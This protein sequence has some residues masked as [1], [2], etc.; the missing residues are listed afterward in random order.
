MAN[1]SLKRK[2]IDTLKEWSVLLTNDLSYSSTETLTTITWLGSPVYRK[3]ID[4]GALPNATS[5]I[6][7]HG[8]TG[9]NYS[10]KIEGIAISGNTTI[11]L[12][13]SNDTGAGGLNS[14]IEIF[15]NNTNIYIYT[16]Q[17]LTSWNGY[18]TLFYIK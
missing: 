3:T 16:G 13:Y 15:S 9:L 1:Y 18:V 8:I 12:P 7:A 4:V 11:P 5:K 14:N 17:D 6:V 2:I 10:V